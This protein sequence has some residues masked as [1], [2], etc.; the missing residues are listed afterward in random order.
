MLLSSKVLDI[1]KQN[2][3]RKIIDIKDSELIPLKILAVKQGTNLK[4]YIENLLSNH[5]QNSHV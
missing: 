4:N 5:V 3:M 2:K 1:I